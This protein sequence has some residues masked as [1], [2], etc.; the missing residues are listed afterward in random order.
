MHGFLY[1][2]CS[3]MNWI[4]LKY[5]PQGLIDNMPALGQILACCLIGDQPFL[6][7]IMAQFTYAYMFHSAW[8]V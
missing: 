7:P 2:I 6:E 4:L 5:M 8:I 1:D 3:I